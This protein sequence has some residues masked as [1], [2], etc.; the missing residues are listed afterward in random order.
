MCWQ[1]AGTAEWTSAALPRGKILLLQKVFLFSRN[2]L[3]QFSEMNKRSRHNKFISGVG[4]DT[5]SSFWGEMRIALGLPLVTFMHLEYS[6]TGTD[7]LCS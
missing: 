7:I 1:K 2:P 4:Q 6:G 5:G 3:L